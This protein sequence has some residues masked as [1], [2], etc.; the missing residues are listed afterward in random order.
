MSLNHKKNLSHYVEKAQSEL[1]RRMGAFFAFS[2]D[3][4]N[5]AK[6][7]NTKYVPLGK[8]GLICPV[9]NAQATI[10][11]VESIQKEGIK[12]RLKDHSLSDLIQYELANYESQ[13][14]MDPSEAFSA[15]EDHGVTKEMMDK[16]F[17]IYM[18]YCYKHDLF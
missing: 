9:E 10:D 6:Q 4:F 15:L 5:E 3:Q 18:D 7:E 16:E 2:D 1:F 17:K 13:I 11:G 8:S 12:L 14:T